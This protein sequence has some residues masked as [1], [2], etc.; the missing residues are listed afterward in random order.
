M[1]KT[2][3]VLL[4][5][6]SIIIFLFIMKFFGWTIVVNST[7]IDKWLLL[8]AV[9]S[10]PSS[11]YII[12]VKKNV[13]I[14]VA[15]TLSIL[16]AIIVITCCFRA[17]ILPPY[18]YAYIES[19]NLLSKPYLVSEKRNVKTALSKFD[20]F[21]TKYTIYKS[22]TPFLFKKESTVVGERGEIFLKKYMVKTV[23]I[24]GNIYITSGNVLLPIK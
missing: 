4:S 3:I 24:D 21:Y 22:I 18:T 14:R 9:F 1:K 2:Y 13:N 17:F 6:S 12:S 7:V 5:L 15:D 10:F 11:I 20:V 19:N 23:E 8:I 16:V